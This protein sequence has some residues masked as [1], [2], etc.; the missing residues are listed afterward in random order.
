MNDRKTKTMTPKERLQYHQKH[1]SSVIK[2]LYQYCNDLII[3]KVV[4]PNSGLGKAI[5]Y[6]NNHKKGLSL[7]LKNGL[8]PL[9][10]NAGERIVKA[11]Y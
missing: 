6:L 9:S 10:N 5:N 7:F 11:K 1:S 4:E 3:N 2:Q 8:A